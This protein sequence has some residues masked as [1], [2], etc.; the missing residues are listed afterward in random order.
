M[1][2]RLASHLTSTTRQTPHST[3]YS[4]RLRAQASPRIA[5]DSD[6]RRSPIDEQFQCRP[7]NWNRRKRVDNGTVQFAWS[8][9]VDTSDERTFIWH[10]IKNTNDRGFGYKWP[11]ADLRRALGS[12]L[13][14]GKTDCNRYFVTGRTAPDDNA[15]IKYGTNETPQRATVFAET[16]SSAAKSTSSSIEASYRTPSGVVELCPRCGTEAFGHSSKCHDRRTR[17]NQVKG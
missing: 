10:Y 6:R 8:T 13:E 3:L 2:I 1:S 4:S 14:P 7:R 5:I 9:D 12:P 17:K 16:T 11:K 15:P